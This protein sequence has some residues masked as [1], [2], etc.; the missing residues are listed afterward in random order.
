MYR[1]PTARLD[2]LNKRV[3]Q[4]DQENTPT[5]ASG[6]ARNGD[7]LVC[8]NTSAVT[9]TLPASPALNS[10]ISVIRAGTGAV[11]ISGNGET[12]LGESTQSMPSQYDAADMVYTS[13][14]WLLE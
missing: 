9:I 13:T 1:W 11:T 8:T 7:T 10:R 2:L 6:T 3:P 4:L 12:I 5:T 14:G